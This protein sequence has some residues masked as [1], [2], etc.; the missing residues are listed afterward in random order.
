[1]LF[2]L[3]DSREIIQC[4]WA[5]AYLGAVPVMLPPALTQADTERINHVSDVTNKAPVLVDERTKPIVT[6][7]LDGVDIYAVNDLLAH[8]DLDAV[9]RK[10]VV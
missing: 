3:T 2:Q 5:C 6:A 4:F 7:A 1:M 9:D 8:P 10:S